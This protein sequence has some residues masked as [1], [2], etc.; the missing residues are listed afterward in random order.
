DLGLRARAERGHRDHGRH[1]DDHAEH[2][3]SR[4]QLVAF[5][6]AERNPHGHEERHGGR[7]L[8]NGMKG[9]G[10]GSPLPLVLFPCLFPLTSSLC[11]LP[12]F[13]P[14]RMIGGG[15]TI[16]APSMSAAPPPSRGIRSGRRSSL[17]MS[18]IRMMRG[19][20]MMTTSVCCASL[21][22]L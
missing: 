3:Q 6:R 10:K 13:P 4:P 15:G 7:V 21:W 12:Y 17:V 5:Q 18:S 20:S 11:P 22:F 1:A 2:R 16:G 9:K 14:P 19:V 8:G